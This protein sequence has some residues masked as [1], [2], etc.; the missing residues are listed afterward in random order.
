MY[1]CI[2]YL[3]QF[4]IRKIS[5]CRRNST[6]SEIYMYFD[7]NTFTVKTLMSQAYQEEISWIFG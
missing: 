7:K 4:D 2:F 6:V 5:I 1:I 3:T